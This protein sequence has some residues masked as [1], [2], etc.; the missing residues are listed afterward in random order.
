[1]TYIKLDVNGVAAYQEIEFG[2]VLRYCDEN[3]VTLEDFPPAGNGGTPV[4][5]EP[6]RLDWML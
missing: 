3:G 1:M 4:D 6:P 2:Q 5:A